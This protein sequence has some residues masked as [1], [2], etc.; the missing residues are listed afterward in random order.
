MLGMLLAAEEPAPL[1]GI[2]WADATLSAFIATVIFAIMVWYMIARARAGQKIP[3]IRKLPGLDAFDEAIGRATEMGRPVHYSPGISGAGS[4][5]TIAS[6]AILGHVA[7][8]C[9]K[10]DTR[11]IQT[12]ADITTYG[13]AEEVVRQAY[14]EAGRPDAFNAEDVRFL[15]DWQFG[16]ASGVLGIFQREKPAANICIGAFWAEA[17]L[18]MEAGVNQ[19]MIQVAGTNNNAQLPFFVAAADYALIAEEIYAASAYLSKEPVMIGTVVAEDWARIILFAL[20]IVGTVLSFFQEKN[21]LGGIL[22]K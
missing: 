17:L 19:G 4:T 22:K 13:V 8:L 2:F 1:L 3:E 20:I 15:S 6:F 7:K 14:L 10:Y 21:W 12:N 16:Y 11:L 18:F 5:Q 9:A